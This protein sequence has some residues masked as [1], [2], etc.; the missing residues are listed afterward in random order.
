M[1]VNRAIECLELLKLQLIEEDDEDGAD[2]EYIEA[3]GLAIK[4]L[5][6]PD[7]DAEWHHYND[8]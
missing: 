8:D 3:L 1:T 6:E 7:P 4:V 5:S 2:E